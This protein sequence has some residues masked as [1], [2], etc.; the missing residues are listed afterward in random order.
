MRYFAGNHRV[1][2]FSLFSLLL[3][4]NFVSFARQKRTYFNFKLY[5]L[6]QRTIETLARDSQFETVSRDSPEHRDLTT[7]TFP[8][9]FLSSFFDKF[10]TNSNPMEVRINAH[11]VNARATVSKERRGRARE[12][13][14]NRFY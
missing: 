13:E 2:S 11:R 5:R 3:S 1:S 9:T 7:H 10:F 4:L 12:R 6:C 14:K 8:V